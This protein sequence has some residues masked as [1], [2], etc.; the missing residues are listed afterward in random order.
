MTF[1]LSRR[2]IIF[3][4][5]TLLFLLSQFYRASVAVITPDLIRELGLDTRGLSLISASFFYAFALTQIPIGMY[6]DTIGP[7]IAM[8]AL[9]LLG[10]AGALVFAA[11][12]SIGTLVAGR[13]LLGAGMACNLMGTLKLITLWFPP[14]R[15]A[16]LGALVLSFGTLGNMT[17]AT[18]LVLAVQAMGWRM[19][20]VV[21]AGINILL[22]LL[23]FAA[24]RDRPDTPGAAEPS[25]AVS[26]DLRGVG[27]NLRALMGEKDYWIIALGAFCRYGIFAAVQAL[28]AAPYLMTVIGI[29]PVATGNM[30]LL[31][32]IGVIIG[33]PVHGWFSDSVFKTRKG[34]IMTGLI[35]MTLV[36]IILACLPRGT[37][38][39]VLSPLFF[40]FGFF[41][42]ACQVMYAHIKERV[43]I[44]RA[45]T[46]MAGVN[47]FTM[48]GVAVY[49]QGLGSL[50]QYLYRGESLSAPAFRAA[51]F[52]CAACLVLAVVLY[53]FTVETR[54]KSKKP[55]ERG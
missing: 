54:G 47:F 22:A 13:I 34:V 26:T 55:A 29:S 35:G 24:A 48:V 16:T 3:S 15:F 17:A 5:A 39:T 50:M 1:A 40:A 45:G 32:G 25:P 42:S 12:D 37:G 31:M 4:T 10:A 38:L 9:S 49:L 11:G 20:F 27:S 2:W 44:E 43:P 18:P 14:L 33:S 52:F 53:G 7:R 41:T 36:L 6:L 28:W 19:S 30:L 51:F 46:A 8:T 21:F 23:F